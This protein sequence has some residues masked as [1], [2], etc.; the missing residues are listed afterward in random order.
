[1][2]L[3]PHF[4]PH[5]PSRVGRN[6]KQQGYVLITLMLFVALMAIA[7]LAVEPVV[8]FQAKR[9]RE[10]ELVHR[11][12]QYAR[13]V[14]LYFKKLGRYPTRLEELED[15][16]NLRFLRK[17]Y[18]DPIT[19][20]DFKLLRMGDV[21]MTFGPGI[22]G[23]TPV[24][25]MAAG[26]GLQGKTRMAGAGAMNPT[27]QSGPTTGTDSAAD[28]D[29]DSSSDKDKDKK[30][31]KPSA[32]GFSGPVFG[33]GPIVGVASTSTKESVREFNRK[34]HYDQWQFIYDPSTD[35]GGLLN[36]PAQPS[37]QGFGFPGGGNPQGMPNGGMNPMAQPAQPQQPTMPQPEN[38]QPE[39]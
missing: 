25:A 12:V 14:R 36:T 11:G 4:P 2:R 16:N 8:A 31:D 6:R 37:L 34:N 28:A 7:W 30:E 15:T 19:G 1:M 13:A 33:G 26:P 18:K 21:K 20:E 38:P 24:T 39:N 3:S 9:D 35:R 23:A 29:S 5:S 17:R 27:Q 32:G 22:Q 10:E